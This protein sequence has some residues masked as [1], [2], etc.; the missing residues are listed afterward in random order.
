MV[1]PLYAE[2][3]H[4]LQR[5]LA[6]RPGCPLFCFPVFY[7]ES[8]ILHSKKPRILLLESHKVKEKKTV[9]IWDQARQVFLLD[10]VQFSPL[11]GIKSS[12]APLVAAVASFV[13]EKTKSPGWKVQPWNLGGIVLS[14]SNT[15]S[16]ITAFAL[17]ICS[18]ER[19]TSGKSATKTPTL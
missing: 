7:L 8:R 18:F 15:L 2:R 12:P 6:G 10:C 19:R 4:S 13:Q 3:Y 11:Q 16:N 9:T 1:K 17:A 5:G 14:V